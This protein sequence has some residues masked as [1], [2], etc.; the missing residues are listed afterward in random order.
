[1]TVQQG[2]QQEGIWGEAEISDIAE[3]VAPLNRASILE[4]GA[5]ETGHGRGAV[6]RRELL[7]YAFAGVLGLLTLGSGVAAYQFLYPR[8]PVN[9]F[10]GKLSLGAALN[11]PSVGG[12]PQFNPI[13]RFYL[14]NTEKG[15]HALYNLCTHS[16]D[17]VRI[18]IW[19]E[20][21]QS[22]FYCPAC[23]SRFCPDGDYILGPAPRSLD[24]FV[25][26][27]VKGR[28]VLAETVPSDKLIVAPVVLSPDAETVVDTGKLLVG[29]PRAL[30]FRHD[31]ISCLNM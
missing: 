14:V 21:E 4:P 23:G 31:G 20:S 27:F 26:E 7:T 3:R 8:A 12:E 6:N 25:I 29:A 28:T 16:W 9:E 2:E 11:L 15:P 1:M 22:N 30:T 19:W 17:G 18:K 13:G 10:G 5:S 24:Q